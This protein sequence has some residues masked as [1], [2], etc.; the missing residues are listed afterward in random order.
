MLDPAS[1]PAS[2]SAFVLVD[3][4]NFS[5]NMFSLLC[6]DSRHD[7]FDINRDIEF[8]KNFLTHTCDF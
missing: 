8:N 5:R 3:V 2:V 7:Y 6:R 4:V 1:V